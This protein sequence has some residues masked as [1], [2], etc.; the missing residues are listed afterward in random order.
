MNI[1]FIIQ[2][3][4]AGIAIAPDVQRF[5]LE[6]KEFISALFGSGLITKAQQD[7]VHA[8]VDL[9]AAAVSGGQIPPEFTVEPDPV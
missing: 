2:L 4:Q 8:H 1:L 5:I 7:R 9:L 6:S 3:I